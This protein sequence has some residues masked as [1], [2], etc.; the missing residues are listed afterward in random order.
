[1]HLQQR[2]LHRRDHPRSRGVYGQGQ[3]STRTGQ[4]SSPLA[5]GLHREHERGRHR[6]RIIPARAGFTRRQGASPRTF[7]DHPRSR[8]VYASWPTLTAMPLGSSPLARGLQH[9][10]RS[11]PQGHRIIPA[12]AGFTPTTLS[13]ASAAEDHPR[14][15]GVYHG[16]HG[17]DGRGRGSSPLARGLRRGF[18]H[19]PGLPGII[20]ARAG[21][22]IPQRCQERRHPD[23][24][25]SRGVYDR[26]RQE[27]VRALWIIPARAGFTPR[28][29]RGDPVAPDHPRSRGVYTASSSCAWWCWGSSPL[30]R[31][32]PSCRS[33]V[34]PP[35]SDHPRSRG[36][37][38]RA[39][40]RPSAR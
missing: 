6:V 33:G 38:G 3:R 5:R 10:R 31:G 39:A 17:D 26:A 40:R 4:G 25:R 21:F 11:R 29:P 23:H 8:G 2:R 34:T 12:R 22:T 18:R 16:L 20:P 9:D 36:V 37:Y 27:I 14:S 7:W 1:M 15:R 19:A 28:S 24:P 13:P 32:L 35:G 30:A